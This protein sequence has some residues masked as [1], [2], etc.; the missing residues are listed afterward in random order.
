MPPAGAPRP[1]SPEEN[2][3]SHQHTKVQ[4]HISVTHQALPQ[5][6]GQ[7]LQEAGISSPVAPTPP[8]CPATVLCPQF[9]AAWAQLSVELEADY[10]FT[11]APAAGSCFVSA[12]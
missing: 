6:K 9:C 12:E 7:H 3:P 1:P 10:L 2:H 4:G 11:T 8:P 5:P